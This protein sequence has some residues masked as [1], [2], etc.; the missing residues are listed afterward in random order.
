VPITVET[1]L[2]AFPVVGVAGREALSELF[3]FRLELVA[4]NAVPLPLD[5]LVGNAAFVRF[6]DGRT[7]RHFSGICARASQGERDARVTAYDVELVPSFWLLTRT[8]GS[9]AFERLSVPEIVGRTLPPGSTSIE[10]GTPFH[11][12]EY[13]VQ[14]RETDFDFVSRL[15]EEE[16]IFYF[17]RH[18]PGGHELVLA[19]TPTG[20][21][22]LGTIRFDA[23]AGAGTI[24]A[25]EKTQELRSGKVTLRDHNFQLPE[26]VVEAT[27]TIQESVPV[28]TV[29]HRLRLDANEALELYDYPGGYAQRFDGV[30]PGGGEQPA[31]LEKIFE[32]AARTTGV[33]MEEETARSLEVAGG[34]TVPTLAAGHAFALDGHA[35]GNGRYVV[36][37]VEHRAESA[38]GSSRI[39]YS[40]TFTCIPA[41]LP[42]R[43]RRRTPQPVIPG[44]QPAV[45]VGPPGEDV[46]TDKHGRVKV[47]FHWDREGS[48]S[49]WIRVTQPFGQ[50]APIPE[51]GDEVLVAFMHGDPSRPYVVGGLFNP[52]EDR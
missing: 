51:I 13:V 14:Y 2:G 32:D 31:E 23:R 3:R 8:A 25:W 48:S 18:T 1:P 43:P 19:N 39:T 6:D 50:A 5:R 49:V 44:V 40:N 38:A 33:R 52:P 10:L 9:R 11:A 15:L 41:G 26:P 20:H 27:A 16:G 28:G 46:F 34:S 4:E 7:V 47:Q 29:E 35:D 22:D 45:V 37:S 30:D 12:R 42:Y 24:F 21:P 36:T 17:F